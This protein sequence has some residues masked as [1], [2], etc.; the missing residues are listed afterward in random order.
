MDAIRQ[1]DFN[2]RRLRDGATRQPEPRKFLALATGLEPALIARFEDYELEDL[3]S[4]A[5]RGLMEANA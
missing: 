2:S 5:V 1:L 4:L 3:T